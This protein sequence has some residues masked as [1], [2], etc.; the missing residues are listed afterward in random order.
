[1]LN[2]L[3]TAGKETGL[4]G[5]RPGIA[6][7]HAGRDTAAGARLIAFQRRDTAVHRERFFT[8]EQNRWNRPAGIGQAADN[9]I[10]HRHH[11]TAG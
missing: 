4:V 5:L 2:D 10:R 1:M 8:A 3:M 6:E 7:M 9:H 11:C